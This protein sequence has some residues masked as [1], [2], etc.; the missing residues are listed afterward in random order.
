MRCQLLKT[1]NSHTSQQ[2]YNLFEMFRIFKRMEQITR[3]TN[4]LQRID[5]M[6]IQKKIKTL[7]I[8]HIKIV[9]HDSK[10]EPYDSACQNSF[11]ESCE[12][13]IFSHRT[14]N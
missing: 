9:L 3:Q 14:D 7:I 10:N 11:N 4:L 8:M 5:E 13:E 1:S 6:K 12:F 2:V